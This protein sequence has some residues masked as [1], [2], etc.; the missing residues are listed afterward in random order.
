[1][2]DFYLFYPP[3]NEL[4][5]NSGVTSLNTLTGALILAA[6]S[7]IT[8]TPSGGNTLTIAS[9]GGGGGGL[10]SLN[11]DT[12]AAQTLTVGT[13]GTDF[14]IVNA[15]GGSHVLNLP[16]ASAS[17]RGVITSAL[18]NSFSAK[19]SP[20][21]ANGSIFMGSGSNLAVASVVGGDL[22]AVF[23][24]AS[25][26]ARFT[27]NTVQGGVTFDVNNT[28]NSIMKRDSSGITYIGELRADDIQMNPVH[29]QIFNS[30]YVTNPSDTQIADFTNAIWNN[31]NGNVFIDGTNLAIHRNDGTYAIDIANSALV[32]TPS[33]NYN[34]D[35][36]D[37]NGIKIPQRILQYNGDD[38]SATSGMTSIPYNYDA[39]G[40]T[41]FPSNVIFTPPSAGT[42]RITT[43]INVTSPA[44]GSCNVSLNWTDSTGFSQHRV[45]MYTLSFSAKGTA[46]TDYGSDGPSFKQGAQTVMI[47]TDSSVSDVI[48][49]IPG[50]GSSVFDVHV[51]VE[52]VK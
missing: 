45:I 15:G 27:V 32:S 7:N 10:T 40:V 21:L 28:P 17:N 6:G 50:D 2:S 52:R 46:L 38:V 14:A 24:A 25:P 48:L 30:S 19:L 35:F 29:G 37:D 33:E 43:V 41:S 42:Y 36:S 51:I 26:Q 9:T 39:V 44:S 8:I 20:T 13:S 1:M 5:I 47:D 31:I 23:N 12:T 22:S 34:L 4:P 11:S 16:T 18:F 49:D 3:A